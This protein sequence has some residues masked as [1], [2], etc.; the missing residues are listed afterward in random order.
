MNLNQLTIHAARELLC[1]S[2]NQELRTSIKGLFLEVIK[3]LA[4]QV[5]VEV[6][7]RL[8]EQDGCRLIAIQKSQQSQRLVETAPLSDDVE[9]FAVLAV[10]DGDV[11]ILGGIV[12]W[13]LNLDREPTLSNLS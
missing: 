7:I 4:L 9:V 6:S 1:V 13:L 3:N 2:G 10:L 12:F 11:D 8:V 5:D